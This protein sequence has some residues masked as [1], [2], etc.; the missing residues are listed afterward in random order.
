MKK[1]RSIILIVM[2]SVVLS[3]CVQNQN[4]YKQLVN[5]EEPFLNLSPVYV[6][7]VDDVFSVVILEDGNVEKAVQFSRNRIPSNVIDVDLKLAENIEDYL[8][9]TYVD[10][11]HIWGECHANIGS[12]MSM[13]SYITNDGYLVSF[14]IIDGIVHRVGKIDLLSGESVELYNSYTDANDTK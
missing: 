13:P 5:Q 8:G 6:Y 9:K 14:T 1:I 10:I 11:E 3:G 2:T 7:N 4:A 12:G